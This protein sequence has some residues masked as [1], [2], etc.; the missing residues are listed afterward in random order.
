MCVSMCLLMIFPVALAALSA[1]VGVHLQ[2]KELDKGTQ[3]TIMSVVGWSVKFVLVLAGVN[4]VLIVAMAVHMFGVYAWCA[5]KYVLGSVRGGAL[6][7][8]DIFAWVFL[9]P[10]KLFALLHQRV[11]GKRVEIPVGKVENDLDPPMAE[12]KLASNEVRLAS[13]EMAIKTSPFFPVKVN[14]KP[15]RPPHVAQLFMKSSDSPE[16]VELGLC[17]AVSIGGNPYLVTTHH[18]YDSIGDAEVY[19]KTDG[20][21]LMVELGRPAFGSKASSLDYVAFRVSNN[22]FARL[23]M[24][25]ATMSKACD[26]AHVTAYHC[27]NGTWYAATGNANMHKAYRIKHAASTLPGSSGSPLMQGGKVVGIH[28]ESLGKNAN[29]GSIILTPSDLRGVKDALASAKKKEAKVYIAG[30]GYV[31]WSQLTTAEKQD[32]YSWQENADTDD[33]DDRWEN[34]AVYDSDDDEEVR[35]WSKGLRAYMPEDEEDI[36]VEAYDKPWRNE[37]DP[38]NYKSGDRDYAFDFSW[39]K[40]SGNGSRAA[41][42]PAS[43]RV[44]PRTLSPVEMMMLNSSN[45]T[46]AQ[47]A[48]L[49]SAFSSGEQSKY[50]ALMAIARAQARKEL[51]GS[52][53]AE[54]S[55][56]PTPEPKS[57]ASPPPSTS[58]P[59]PSDPPSQDGLGQNVEATPSSTP[60]VSK[61]SAE[62]LAK[63]VHTQLGACRQLLVVMDIEA[64]KHYVEYF[65]K[66]KGSCPKLAWEHVLT[67]KQVKAKIQRASK[68][69]SDSSLTT[70]L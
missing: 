31:E 29:Q 40:E 13:K 45:L 20:L 24:K 47:R 30:R 16:Y 6:G 69:S 62:Q 51:K 25:V 35:F 38:T 52:S 65:A 34:H 64:M 39:M 57:Q 26:N 70:Q 66:S 37:Y 67:W 11:V 15:S 27:H 50:E 49:Q 1:A 7:L 53:T 68:T 17:F 32:Y 10:A 5:C 48:S 44:A 19:L 55:P 61:P 9:G 14:G 46:P 18:E 59:P 56:V 22:T 36:Q 2:F 4:L 3:E 33:D 8:V 58:E 23:G 60:S 63:R 43:K 42:P 41:P 54:P 12:V 28:T 21:A